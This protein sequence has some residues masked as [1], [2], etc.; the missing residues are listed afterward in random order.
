MGCTQ[1]QQDLQD[2][3]SR[4]R[5]SG[6]KDW[7]AEERTRE[8][9]GAITQQAAVLEGVSMEEFTQK[10][11]RVVL[12]RLAVELHRIESTNDDG[13]RFK[14]LRDIM[15]GVI[16]MKR[17]AAE[18]GRLKREQARKAGFLLPE[19]EIEKQFWLWAAD[20]ENKERV[21]RR[22]FM[23]KE[24][25]E[26]AIDEL[27]APDA[28]CWA[29]DEEYIRSI[30]GK[31]GATLPEELFRRKEPQEPEKKPCSAKIPEATHHPAAPTR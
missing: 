27:L 16:S 20:P 18:S 14:C 22:L 24:Q 28:H 23:T 4:W 15:W 8:A 9:Y 19:E 10:M 2:G 29:A 25:K 5:K 26:A 6:Y 17:E 1:D 11:A 30:G 31:L 13:E 7:L 21:R 3:E 12:A